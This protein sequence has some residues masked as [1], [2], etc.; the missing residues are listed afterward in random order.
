[1]A[2]ARQLIKFGFPS[3]LPTG[4]PVLCFLAGRGA[5]LGLRDGGYTCPQ[6]D[7]KHEEV[8]TECPVRVTV[9]NRM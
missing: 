3:R 9:C 5:E 6:C 4:R 8:P 1:M 2:P 7:A